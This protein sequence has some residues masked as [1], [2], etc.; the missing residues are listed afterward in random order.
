V[1]H[2][3]E[4]RP[5]IYALV[6]AFLAVALAFV[7]STV[8][9]YLAS[10][11]IDVAAQS[12]LTNSL[13]SVM[14]LLRARSAE[15]R[16]DIDVDVLARMRPITPELLTDLE[17][18]HAELKETLASA[19]IT[20]NY[21]GERELYEHDVRPRIEQLDRAFR[22]V[23]VTATDPAHR[24]REAEALA[25]LDSSAREL[26]AALQALANLNLTGG[27]QATSRILSAHA[28]SI[29][30]AQYLDIV[31]CI[32]A[33]IAA[34][35]VVRM[36]IRFAREARRR[37]E[38]ERDRAR[39]LDV[40]AQRVAHDLMSPLG[41]VSLSLASVERTNQDPD[42]A[43]A[44]ERANRALQRSRQMVDGI[45]AFSR[46][47]AH[48]VPGAAGPLRSTIV[49]AV[50][51]VLEMEAQSPPTIEVQP[52]EDAEVAMDPAVLNVIISNLLSN[53]AKFC[54]GSPLR[55]VTVRAR[56]DDERVH[57]EVEDTGPGVP[58]GLEEAIFEPYVRAPEVS[59]PGLGLG[60]A[61]VRRL[62]V[63]HGGKVGVRR[64][65]S[66]G[67]IFWFELPRAAPHRR[68]RGS[69]EAEQPLPAGPAKPHPAH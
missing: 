13:P 56:A 33:I 23:Q 5:A 66:G 18:A 38:L 61:T 59:Q 12:L 45:Y 58:P 3:L 31:S 53:A 69:E 8:G 39:E 10:R 55:N 30:R 6:A 37:L 68:Q 34:A 63:S 27:F 46:A 29:R 42:A 44:L 50:R 15:R 36:E 26:D 21:P 67:A 47:G 24:R 54:R 11:E 22:D 40:L 64:A 41:A 20:P 16:F 62:V 65:R 19:M 4:H 49:E 1:H 9:V 52:F 7:F 57:V 35:L 60:L 25:V 43:R 32:L 48:P 2:R 28:E 14:A 51:D 17:D